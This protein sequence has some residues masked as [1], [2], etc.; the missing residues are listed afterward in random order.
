MGTGGLRPARTI[1]ALPSFA[2][3]MGGAGVEAGE[4]VQAW[5]AVVWPVM[6]SVTSEERWHSGIAEVF[7]SQP[8]NGLWF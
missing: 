7:N 3:D 8:R 2:P 6:A 5:R 1:H 4:T